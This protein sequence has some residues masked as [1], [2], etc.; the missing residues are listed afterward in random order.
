M[1]VRSFDSLLESNVLYQ[2]V[3]LANA[4]VVNPEGKLLIQDL[5]QAVAK[6]SLDSALKLWCWRTVLPWDAM[7]HAAAN[8]FFTWCYSWKTGTKVHRKK[9]VFP[10]CCWLAWSN[11]VAVSMIWSRFLPHV[12]ARACFFAVGSCAVGHFKLEPALMTL[13]FQTCRYFKTAM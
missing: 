4:S 9:P 5:R 7:L 11:H 12:E 1:R 10:L 8:V 6:T 2:I 13:T 3:I